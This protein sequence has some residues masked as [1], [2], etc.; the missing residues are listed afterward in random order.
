MQTWT[1]WKVESLKV[2]CIVKMSGWSRRSIGTIQTF[3]CFVSFIRK[4]L[5][6]GGLP[7]PDSKD[8]IMKDK[9]QILRSSHF[10]TFEAHTE[11]VALRISAVV[12]PVPSSTYALSIFDPG[13]SSSISVWIQ[14]QIECQNHSVEYS[15]FECLDSRCL[16]WK[17]WFVK[18]ITSGMTITI[19]LEEIENMHTITIVLEEIENMHEVFQP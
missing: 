15:S 2:W 19:V 13:K 18:V 14:F 17:K 9:C 10:I 7:L 12:T 16:P 6:L 8:N 11:H 3:S 4:L 5:G 1:N